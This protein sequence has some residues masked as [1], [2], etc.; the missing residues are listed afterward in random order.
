MLAKKAKLKMEI[1]GC[2]ACAELSFIEQIAIS[3][4]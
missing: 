1:P 3:P 2:V 4:E